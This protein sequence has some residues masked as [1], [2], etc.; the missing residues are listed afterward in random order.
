[1]SDI[2][3]IL[4][5]IFAQIVWVTLFWLIN[6]R[7]YECEERILVLLKIIEISKDRIDICDANQKIFYEL[8]KRNAQ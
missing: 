4:I 7:L 8:H 6:K 2:I 5:I 1:M 3:S